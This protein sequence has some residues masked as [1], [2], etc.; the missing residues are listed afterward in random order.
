M[1]MLGD[2]HRGTIQFGVITK[3]GAGFPYPVFPTAGSKRENHGIGQ[4]RGQE[5]VVEAPAKT[6]R[7]IGPIGNPMGSL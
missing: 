6:L 5:A 3:E 7:G 2:P 4:T 1:G